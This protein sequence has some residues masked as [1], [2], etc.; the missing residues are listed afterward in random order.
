MSIK[1]VF[2]YRES[3]IGNTGEFAPGKVIGLFWMLVVVYISL[4]YFGF[5]PSP[6]EG[7]SFW[8]WILSSFMFGVLSAGF[9]WQKAREA[10]NSVVEAIGDRIRG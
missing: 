3:E 9:Y 1:D 5:V 7:M 8:E 6:V 10:F 4:A 2:T